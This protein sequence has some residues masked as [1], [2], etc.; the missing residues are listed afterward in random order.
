MNIGLNTN[1]QIMA[2]RRPVISVG[3]A[4]DDRAEGLGFESQ[5]GPTLRVLKITEENML[6]LQ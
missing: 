4:S 2:L 3:R 5:T 1:V 6:P